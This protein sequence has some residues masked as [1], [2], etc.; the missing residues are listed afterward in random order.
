MPFTPTLYGRGIFGKKCKCLLAS[1]KENK[2]E[3]KNSH[4]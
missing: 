2:D 1:Q 4:G 3:D